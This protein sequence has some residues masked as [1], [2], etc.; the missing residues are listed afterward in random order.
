MVLYHFLSV[1]S[2]CP[3]ILVISLIV[4]D[5]LLM[6]LLIPPCY[7]IC[8]IQILVLSFLDF[9]D[10]LGYMFYIYYIFLHIHMNFPIVYLLLLIHF[11]MLRICI[12]IY[13]CRFVHNSLPFF[14]AMIAVLFL[15][16]CYHFYYCFDF[17]FYFYF[18]FDCHQ[19]YVANMRNWYFYCMF[20]FLYLILYLLMVHFLVVF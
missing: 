6:L 20:H 2:H 18:Y 19:F 15:F 11:D 12:H 7:T 14:V 16:V 3:G 10:F 13:L 1:A 17:Y 5:V 8:C 9:L 4:F